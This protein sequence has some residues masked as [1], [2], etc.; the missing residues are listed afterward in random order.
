MST[1][2]IKAIIMHPTVMVGMIVYSIINS[3]NPEHTQYMHTIK[4]AVT[5]MSPTN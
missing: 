4:E 2:K 3:Q 1:M 5:I